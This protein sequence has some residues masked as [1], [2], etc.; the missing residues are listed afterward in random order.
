MQDLLLSAARAFALVCFADGTLQESEGERFFAFAANE[1]LLSGDARVAF[2]L[3]VAEALKASEFDDL[4]P[5]IVS[6]GGAMDARAVLLRAG[7]VALT[8]DGV[9]APQ[10][11]AAL[12]ALAQALG[13]EV[14]EA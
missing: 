12:A 4:L 13:L 9:N 11:N 8:A 2:G 5:A 3:A 10:E 6:G 7:Q 1:P 14:D